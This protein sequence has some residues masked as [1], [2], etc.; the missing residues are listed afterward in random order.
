MRHRFNRI[1]AL[2]CLILLAPGC[3]ITNNSSVSIEDYTHVKGTPVYILSNP[4]LEPMALEKDILNCI[5][6]TDT[7]VK[8]TNR[9]LKTT[10]GLTAATG[11]AALVSITASGGFLAPLF[12]PAYA[13]ITAI[14]GGLYL[15]ANA[16]EEFREYTGLEKCLEKQGYEVVFITTPKKDQ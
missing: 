16:T 8:I 10:G 6:K 5:D 12:I 2:S 1:I 3:V 15:S 7:K 9:I 14:G 11:I 4:P 13:T